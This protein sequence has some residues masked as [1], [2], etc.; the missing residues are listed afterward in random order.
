MNECEE[1]SFFFLLR[2]E[3]VHGC[4]ANLQLTDHDG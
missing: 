2:T 1:W 4:I 3:Y